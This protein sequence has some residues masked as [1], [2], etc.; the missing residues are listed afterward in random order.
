MTL[1]SG[2]LIALS[3]N[4]VNLFDLRP[5]RALKA[6][7]LGGVPLWLW[8]TGGTPAPELEAGL[9]ALLGA[10]PV[11]GLFEARRRVMLGDAGANM[12]GA[13]L[14]FAAAATLPWP[15]Q[16]AAVAALTALHVYSE[17]HSLSAWIAARPWA[18]ALDRWGWQ[19]PR[20]R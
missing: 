11:Y 19:P 13:V 20:E 16:L 5:L 1:L 8:L 10:A 15:V 12:L 17:K 7:A 4:A 6:F 3:A 9:S 2:L 14:G 18:A